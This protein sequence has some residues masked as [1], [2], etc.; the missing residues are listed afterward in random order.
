LKNRRFKG[1]LLSLIGNA[2]RGLRPESINFSLSTLVINSLAG[3]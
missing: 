1:S 3:G 2:K